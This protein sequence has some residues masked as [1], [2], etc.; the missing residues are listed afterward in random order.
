[1]TWESS[2]PGAVLAAS[3][4][5]PA[6]LP[7]TSPTEPL[8]QKKTPNLLLPPFSDLQQ[9]LQV[10]AASS[11]YL[12][13]PPP[14]SPLQS[15]VTSTHAASTTV[16]THGVPRP[17]PPT[18]PACPV[19]RGHHVPQAPLCH[20][21]APALLL[22]FLPPRAGPG[23]T[24]VP[25]PRA[26]SLPCWYQ[27]PIST[28]SSPA[29]S[30]YRPRSPQY[31][32]APHSTPNWLSI[33]CRA[34]PPPMLGTSR[35]QTGPA[36]PR[37]YQS[38]PSPVPLS[39]SSTKMGTAPPFPVTPQTGPVP[40]FPAS[41]TPQPWGCSSQ[42]RPSPPQPPSPNRGLLPPNRTGPRRYRYLLGGLGYGG[43]ERVLLGVL[44]LLG[45]LHLLAAG[46]LRHRHPEEE[47][48]AAAGR[49]A[50]ARGTGRGGA[51]R[52]GGNAPV[53]LGLARFA[54][55]GPGRPRGRSS[56]A[57]GSQRAAAGTAAAALG[58]RGRPAVTSARSDVDAHRPG[59]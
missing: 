20:S 7:P 12:T 38:P 50:A 3:S 10:T 42:S 44:H 47:E 11:S 49:A 16:L 4:P 8:P 14:P 28:R 6:V 58:A 57:A 36:P 23:L 32:I 30:Q 24:P 18:L 2:A 56:G 9:D 46:G 34:P 52:A 55:T 31:P 39:L 22:S 1:M 17:A 25:P 13:G 51:R 27:A 48:E 33:P 59:K 26:T 21:Q 40:A 53:R 19:A 54:S 29:V 37:R 15:T 5:S 43:H 45:L 41:P 35:P